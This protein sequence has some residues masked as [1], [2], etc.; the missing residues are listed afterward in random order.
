MKIPTLHKNTCCSAIKFWKI[1]IHFQL[2]FD[3]RLRAFFLMLNEWAVI[4]DSSH[5]KAFLFSSLQLFPLITYSFVFMGIIYVCANFIQ[6]FQTYLNMS[7]SL[8][9]SGVGAMAYGKLSVFATHFIT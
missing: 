2:L 5:S 6:G 8:V 4:V 9:V 7:I 3:A 1:L